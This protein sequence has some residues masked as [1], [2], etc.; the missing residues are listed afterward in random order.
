MK[1]NIGDVNTS[2]FDTS[3]I[4]SGTSITTQG[5]K[6][7]SV[8]E[9][10]TYTY[11]VDGKQDGS[12]SENAIEE[13]EYKNL[14]PNLIHTILVEIRDKASNALLGT[15][16]KQAETSN[17]NAPELRGFNPD[18]TYYV[19]YDKDGNETIGD[20]IKQDGSNMPKDWYDYGRAKWANIVVKGKTKEG[21]ETATYFTWIPR[22][23]FKLDQTTQKSDVK[24][25]EGTGGATRGD[26]KVPE[27][28][29]FDG[30]ALTG[31][32]SMKYNIGDK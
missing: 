13:H 29:T 8:K 6:G 3:I 1:Y 21:V 20:K 17:P 16:V 26:Y 15:I 28:F 25:I 5:I 10:Q 19:L 2:L 23:Q 32:W 9:G 27:A 24:F 11:Y 22:Y 31:Y 12:P 14:K 7:N 18:C 30:K 4:I